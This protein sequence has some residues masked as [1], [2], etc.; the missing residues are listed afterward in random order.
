M[1]FPSDSTCSMISV[2]LRSSHSRA[3]V[4]LLLYF[5]V[6]INEGL[7]FPDNPTTT[8]ATKT[9]AS[10]SPSVIFATVKS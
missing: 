7:A 5:I 4:L 10:K 8:K 2:K 9:T 1:V 3:S 6:T